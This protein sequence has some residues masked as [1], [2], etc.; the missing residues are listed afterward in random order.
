MTT[1]NIDDLSAAAALTG[2][3]KSVVAQA[4]AV[5]KRTTLTA[6]RNWIAGTLAAVATSGSKADVGLGNVANIKHDFAATAPPTVNNDSG[7]GY[8]VG[9]LKVWPAAGRAWR[10]DSVT[11]G[12]AIWTEL[13]NYAV[14]RLV[15]NRY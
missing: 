2:T 10:A 7:E 14:P 6:I 13:G 5:L 1:K 8:S 11:A 9:S 4:D 3:D 15:A 12:A